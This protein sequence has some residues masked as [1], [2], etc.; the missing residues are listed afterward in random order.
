M[1][2]LSKVAEE[3]IYVKEIFPY[4]EVYDMGLSIK[5]LVMF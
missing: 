2:N 5:Y 4:I 1:L 3:N